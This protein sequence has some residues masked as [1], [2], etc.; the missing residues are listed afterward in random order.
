MYD[1]ERFVKAQEGVYE[2]ALSEI[3]GGLKE[4][5]WMWYI[6]PQVIGL[7]HTRTNDFFAIKSEEESTEYLKHDVLG[8]RLIEMV[9]V[10]LALNTDDPVSVFGGLDALKLKSSMTLFYEVSGNPIFASVLD[11][12]YMGEEDKKTIDIINSLKVKGDKKK[13][14][15]LDKL[16]SLC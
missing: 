15:L 6:F 1:L 9:E 3:K 7:G 14:S 5:H 12:F 10:L 8:P 2:K 4:T 13:L 11:K 16:K